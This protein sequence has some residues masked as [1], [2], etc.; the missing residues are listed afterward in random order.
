MKC[1][2]RYHSDKTATEAKPFSQ[3]KR[4]A[5]CDGGFP[6]KKGSLWENVKKTLV[7]TWELDRI[8]VILM[9]IVAL[10]R[11]FSPYISIFLSAYILDQLAA[12]TSDFWSLFWKILAGLVMVFLAKITGD[13]LEI[14]KNRHIQICVSRFN[15]K[16]TDKTLEMDYQ[17]L[18]SSYTNDIRSRI[19]IDHMWGSGLYSVMWELP[20]IIEALLQIIVAGIVLIPLIASGLFFQKGLASV[21]LVLLL[22]ISTASAVFQ[23]KYTKKKSFEL[24]DESTKHSSY[25]M[26]FIWGGSSF[27]YKQGKDIRLFDASSMILSHVEQAYEDQV[28]WSRRFTRVT[29]FGGAVYGLSLIHI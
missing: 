24:M 4:G 21:F 14:L 7:L 23:T 29:S 8:V 25:M 16:K 26:Y 12:G 15:M 5:V 27:Q 10:L 13:Y 18:D 17:Q 19:E 28:A 6:S 22:A 1:N 3:K 9:T 11:V 2:G 20:I